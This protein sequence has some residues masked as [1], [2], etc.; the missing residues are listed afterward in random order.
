MGWA[1]SLY[2]PSAVLLLGIAMNKPLSPSITLISCTTNS[3]SKVMDTTAFILPSFAILRTRTSVT[4]ICKTPLSRN[5]RPP[6]VT[7][8]ILHSAQEQ[9]GYDRPHPHS[10][11]SPEWCCDSPQCSF[12][13]MCYHRYTHHSV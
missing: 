4:C 5:L 13:C 3:S 1:I 11:N 10:G 6:R 9:C 8:Y 7:L 12:Q 2:S